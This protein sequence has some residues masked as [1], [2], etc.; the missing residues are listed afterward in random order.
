MREFVLAMRAIWAAWNEGERLDFQGDFYTHTLMPPF[1]NPGPNPFGAPPVLVAAVGDKMTQVAGEVADG[2]VLHPFTTQRYVNEVTLPALERGFATTD[3]TRADFTVSAAVFVV[4]GTTDAEWERARAGTQQQIAFYGSTPGYR[5]VLRVHGWEDVGI[6]LTE[7]SRRGDT[8]AMTRL[9]SDEMLDTFAVSAEPEE[10]GHA[11]AARYDGVLDRFSFDAPCSGLRS[12][13]VGRVVEVSRPSR[14]ALRHGDRG[15]RRVA[16]NG[17]DDRTGKRGFGAGRR[18]AHG[19][20]VDEDG[21]PRR[22]S[23]RREVSDPGCR[24]GRRERRLRPR[25]DRLSLA[26]AR[27]GVGTNADET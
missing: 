22:S 18:P 27:D 11:V 4:T 19:P 26:R 13:D 16:G 24:R 10:L 17:H 5:N 2:I 9:I 21:D 7:L 14:R 12:A 3:R 1:F 25:R 8:A 6:E 15:A 23:G 20:R